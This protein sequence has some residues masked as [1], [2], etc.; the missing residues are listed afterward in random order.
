MALVSRGHGKWENPKHS[1]KM[2][3]LQESGDR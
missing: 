2:Y 1:G 3:H